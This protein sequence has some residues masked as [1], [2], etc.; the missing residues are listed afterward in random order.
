VEGLLAQLARVPPLPLHIVGLGSFEVW[1]G[2]RRP[3]A[4]AWQRRKAGELLRF[5]LLQPGRAAPHE[6]VLD[7]LWPGQPPEPARAQLY[8]ATSAVRRLLEPDLP[9]KFPSRY[10]QLEADRIVLVLPPGS[11]VDFEQ[12]EADPDAES[13]RGWLDGELF[14]AD[15]YADW[16][17]AA[18]ERV[19]QCQLRALLARARRH[20]AAGQPEPALEACHRVLAREPWSEEAVGLGMQAC[21]LLDDRPGALRLYQALA[22]ALQRDLQLTPRAHLR[23]LAAS[24]RDRGEW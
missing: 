21:L 22:D 6:A 13:A 24:L 5:L 20:L 12:L 1:Q 8:Q 18:R 9:E 10:L 16:A 2:R 17:A 15:R 3:E 14:P 4:R 23:D 11:T 19:A 7:A